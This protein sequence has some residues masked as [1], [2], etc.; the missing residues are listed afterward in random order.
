VR[1]CRFHLYPSGQAGIPVSFDESQ[2]DIVVRALK[3][4]RSRLLH[5]QGKGEYSCEGVLK[6]I[7]S[8]T[9][10]RLA[11]ETSRGTSASI[12]IWERIAA[13][14]EQLPDEVSQGVPAD[15]SGRLDK[16]LYGEPAG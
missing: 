13:L 4:H 1:R 8:V 5:V 15:A 3:E 10:L 2:E 14:G 6:H 16:Y 7:A 11:D 12:P 9:D